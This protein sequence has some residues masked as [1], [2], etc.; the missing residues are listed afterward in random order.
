MESAKPMAGFTLVELLVTLIVLAVAISIGIPNLNRLVTSNR[1]SELLNQ[2]L[3]AFAMARSQ[4]VTNKTITAICPLD[5]S[6]ECHDNWNQPVSIFPD[7]DKDQKPD[8]GEVWRVVTI[9]GDNFNI[10]SRTAGSGS[11][12]FGSDGM[13][14]GGTGSVVICPENVSSKQMTYLAVSLGGRA[15]H[16]TDDDGDGNITLSWGGKISCP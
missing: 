9:D 3:G 16:T 15:R 2:Y 12:H 14:H 1:H 11:F 7:A 6:S 8:N 4:A 13:I 10:H 5:S